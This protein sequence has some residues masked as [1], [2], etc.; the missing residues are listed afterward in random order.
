MEEQ[1]VFK[2]NLG[3]MID[4]LANH[5]YSTPEVF[6]RELLQNGIDAI[7]ARKKQQ[8]DL[9]DAHLRI[10][11][12]P[13]RQL[14]FTDSG[15]GLT[16][17]EIHQFLAVIG[18]SSKRDL[19]T[20]RVYE[21]YIGRFGIGLLSCFMVSDEILVHT[22]SVRD[23]EHAW[24]FRGMPDGTYTIT[25]LTGVKK[26]EI[27]TDIILN[28]KPGAE[29]YYDAERLTE[30]IHY[31]GLPI[32]IPILIAD[33][34]GE[35]QIN[36]DFGSA[37]SVEQL[38]K[39]IFDTDFLGYIPLESAKGLFSGV[40]YIL[41]HAVSVH[42]KGSHRIYL[43]NL[44]L[45]EDGEALLPKWTGFLRCFINTTQLRPT[46]SR[47]SFYEDD[48]LLEAREDL[49]QCSSA[50]LM[51]LSHRNPAL[52]ERIIPV[53]FMAIKSMAAEDED[54][55]RTF[56]PFLHFETNMGELTGRDLLKRRDIIHFS[57]DINQFHRTAALMLAQGQL[58]VNAC[59]VYDASLLRMMQE[60]DSSVELCPLAMVSFDEF[61]TEPEDTGSASDLMRI[62]RMMLDEYDCD[63]Q[64][65]NFSPSTLPVFYMLDED[66]ETL[67]EI[68]HSQEHSGE[69]FASMLSSFAEE[70]KGHRATLYLN[71]SNP[72]I[73]RL[74]SLEDMEKARVALQIL[75]V[76][77]LLTGRFPLQGSEMT[78]F[79]DNLIRLLEW[80]VS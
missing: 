76:Q 32:T 22:R 8:S 15:A 61:L 24:E 9:R 67:R 2:V 53:P 64:L 56:I 55:F 75:Y 66:A 65:K 17:D 33:A 77:S 27:G 16:R 28:A 49:S 62:A 10:K 41:P 51:E 70:L 42:A 26:P 71:W 31:Y 43:K 4:I 13:G 68:R 25:E 30:L 73:R 72:L 45:T 11:V 80:G 7:S 21:D 38:G 57:T 54:F 18:Q 50:Y 48:L 40:A 37:G 23:P 47:E 1:F 74:A 5:L 6:I 59:Y 60:Y 78:V 3:G 39:R 20:G 44:L 58:L 29:T 36:V 14:V 35:R 12:D 34:E 52:L 19:E 79:N 69:M 63:A 46:A